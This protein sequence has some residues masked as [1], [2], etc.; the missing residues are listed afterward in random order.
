MDFGEGLKKIAPFQR[1]EYPVNTS[2]GEF[3]NDV[4]TSETRNR[5]SLRLGTRAVSPISTPSTI[6]STYHVVW[7]V[8]HEWK[9]FYGGTMSGVRCPVGG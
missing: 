5:C 6:E 2:V 9:N 3:D 8:W 7:V 1:S 4:Y